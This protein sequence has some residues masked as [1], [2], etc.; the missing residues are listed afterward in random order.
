MW[1]YDPSTGRFDAD[2][3][4]KALV[5]CCRLNNLICYGKIRR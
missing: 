5:V 4:L 2:G 3:I 1:G